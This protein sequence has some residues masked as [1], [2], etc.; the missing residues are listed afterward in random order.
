MKSTIAT[1]LTFAS[2]AFGLS[3]NASLI[4]NVTS[5]TYTGDNPEFNSGDYA[6]EDDIIK[7]SGLAAPLTLANIDTVTHDAGS[8]GANTWVTTAPNGG[9][10]DFSQA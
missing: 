4:A 1:V 6:N 5:I 10:G 3:A 7:G 2:L 9:A 8:N